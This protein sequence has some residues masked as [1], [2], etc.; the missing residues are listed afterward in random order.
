MNF[1]EFKDKLALF[2]FFSL[3]EVQKIFPKFRRERLNDWQ[4]K[5]YIK[6][7]V[8]KFYIFSDIAIDEGLLF[9]MANRIYGPSYVS[10][11]T[12]LGY[13]GLIPEAV[14]GITSIC[15]KRTYEVNTFCANF[16]YKSVKPELFFA[17]GLEKFNKYVVKMASPEKALLDFFYLHDEINSEGALEEL[18]LNKEVFR[19]KVDQDK[20]KKYL[21]LMENKKLTQRINSL[22]THINNA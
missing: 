10:L 12:A 8:N 5:G 21:P 9:L 11:Q 16:I 6:K 22:L 1:I 18:R 4:T 2:P 15:T 20:L 7:I 13:Y 19:E 14:Y 3:V 17:F